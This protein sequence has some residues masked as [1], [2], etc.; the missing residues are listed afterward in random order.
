MLL[1]PDRTG[2]Q[3]PKGRF[4]PDLWSIGPV[5][6]RPAGG[7]GGQGLGIMSLVLRGPLVMRARPLQT[8]NLA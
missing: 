3:V 1:P 8:R 6:A 4:Y 7:L 2:P 5:K